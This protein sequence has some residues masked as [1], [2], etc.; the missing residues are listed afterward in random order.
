MRPSRVV[1]VTA[2]VALIAQLPSAAALAGAGDGN[3]QSPPARACRSQ[4]P[5][6]PAPWMQ[7]LP[8]AAASTNLSA[9]DPHC[10]TQVRAG[11]DGVI[12]RNGD[13]SFTSRM[14][15]SP[16]NYQDADGSWHAIDTRLAAD[17]QG[18]IVN[19]A[20]PFSV[21]LGTDASSPTL[22]K[23]SRGSDSVAFD[24]VG[25]ASDSGQ[26]VAPAP[27]SVGAIGGADSDTITYASALPNVDLSYEVL[28]EA[29]K[30]SIVLRAPL[31]SGMSPQFE[32]SVRT[33]GLTAK[34]ADDGTIQFVDA[35]GKVAFAVPAGRA[36]DSSGNADGGIDAAST[37]VATQLLP[38]ADPSVS[39]IVVSIDSAW[40]SDPARVFPVTI[41]PTMSGCD[42]S[43]SPAT[44]CVTEDAYVSSTS[45]ST[46]YNGASQYDSGSGQ[47][48]DRT[49]KSG[50]TNYRS[51]LDLPDLSGLTGDAIVSATWNG[52]AYS[53]AG[54]T[55]VSVSAR[56]ID[57]TW[58]PSTVTN[59][60]VPTVRS[61]TASVSV[62][63]AGWQSIDISSFVTN[64][65]DPTSPWDQDGIRLTGPST[66]EVRFAAHEAPLS[67]QPY[68]DITY[69]AIPT[70]SNLTAGG[71]FSA[72][73]V[74]TAT[75]TL[76]AQVSDVDNGNGL[77]VNYSLYNSTKTTLL[78]SGSG[79]TVTDGHN[80]TWTVGSLSDGTYYWKAQAT[81]GTATSPLSGWQPLVVDTVTPNAPTITISGVTANTWLTTGGATASPH[82]TGS[83]STD[84]YGFFWGIDVGNNPT[85]LVAATSNAATVNN[86]PMT[87]G[88]H[89]IAVETVDKAGNISSL[90]HFTFGWGLGGFTTPADDF[91]TQSK[92]VAHVN[93]TPTYNGVALQWRHADTDTWTNIPTGD[94]TYKSSGTGIGSWPVTAT[95][96]STQTSFPDLV[97]NAASTSSST[98][99][100]LQLRMVVYL[101]SFAYPNS[102]STTVHVLLN[103][104]G[105]GSG[106]ASTSAGPGQVN[107][108][109]GNLELSASDVSLA[110]GSLSRIFD[111]RDPSASGGVFGPGWKSNI[112]TSSSPFTSLIDNGSSVVVYSGTDE[113]DFTQLTNTSY[114]YTYKAQDGSTNYTLTKTSSTEFALDTL[115][116][117]TVSFDYQS[118]SASGLYVPTTITQDFMGLT[119]TI[120]WTGTSSVTYPTQIVAPTPAGVSCTSSPLTTRGCDTLTFDYAT[121]TQ[122]TTTCGSGL[123]DVTGQLRTV[124][125]TAWDPDLSTPAMSTVDVETYCYDTTTNQLRATWD[126]RISPALK[127]TY[128]YDT[129]GHI[130]TI[131]PPGVNAMSFSYTP[132]SGEAASTGRLSAVSQTLPTYSGTT[133]ATTSYVYQ[134]PLTTTGGGAYNLDP[135]TT[136]TWGQQD[137]PTDATAVY[138]PDQTPSGTPPSSYTRATIF[139]IDAE[140][141]LVN[142]AE[143]GGGISTTEYD[144]VG[145]VIR[146]LSP[147]DRAEALTATDTVAESRLLDTQTVYDAADLNVTDTYGPAHQVDLPDDTQRISRQ[148]VTY[149]YDENVPSALTTDAP[150]DL[151]TTQTESAAPIDGSAEQDAR[152][153]SFKYDLAGDDTGWE[154]STPLQTIVDPGTSPHLNLATTTKYDLAT[155]QL[156]ARIL[157]ANPSGG[158]AHETDFVAYTVG[159]NSTDSACGYKP[160]WAGLACRQGPAAQPGTAGLPNIP[161]T[162]VTKYNMYGQPEE[163]IDKDGSTTLRTSDV[164]FDAGGR[165]TAQS[166]TSS[167]GT[168]VAQID[169]VYDNS[170][171]NVSTSTFHGTSTGVVR[172]YDALGRL[173]SYQDA[174]GNT[175][176]YTYDALGN[177]HSV[178]DGK[179][180]TTYTY[181]TALDPRGVLT[182]IS[183]TAV[184]GSWSASYDADGNIIS[185]G[186][187]GGNFI[188]AT[189]YDETDEPIGLFYFHCL[190]FCATATTW[191]SFVDT[192]NIHGERT[193][194]QGLLESYAYTYDSAGRLTTTQ[195]A[196]LFDCPKRTY[197]FDADSNRTTF[198]F[199]D[200]GP[201]LGTDCV[202]TGSGTTATH[203][204]DAADR[205]T[206]VGYSYD[207]LARTTSVPV[208][209]SPSGYAT[210][211]G[212]YTNGRVQSMTANGTTSAYDID[213]DLRAHSWN[214]GS[215]SRTNHFAG[216]SDKAAWTSENTA[217]TTW[218]RDIKAF[219][220]LGA[221]ADQT[222]NATLQLA[223]LHGDV[224]STVSTTETDWLAGLYSTS[225]TAT[226]S[227]TDEYGNP[228]TSGQP[229]GT[230]YD[231]LGTQQR[232]RDPGTGLQLM[233]VRV[234]NPSTGR[235]LQTDLVVGG[236]ANSY[237]YAAGDPVNG[238]DLTGTYMTGGCDTTPPTWAALQADEDLGH[239]ALFYAFLK[240]EAN[241]GKPGWGACIQHHIIAQGAARAKPAFNIWVVDLRQ[242]IN[243]PGNVVYIYQGYHWYLHTKQ[244]YDWVNG[245]IG[246][247]YSHAIVSPLVA[248]RTE[249]NYMRIML[250][251]WF[252]CGPDQ[253]PVGHIGLYFYLGGAGATVWPG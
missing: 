239:Y 168:A 186:F 27:S 159:A 53:T 204:Y 19:K 198:N 117:E 152:T 252:G 68:V 31:G 183:D 162:Y 75:P 236:S 154:L 58:N 206:D 169:L 2:A 121:T 128:T 203:A 84:V 157:P 151:V 80:S 85:D 217:G 61:N 57:Q 130:A 199:I 195:Q 59:A 25:A 201:L 4:A 194:D 6:D 89:D 136:A 105:F 247:A 133:T 170:N 88:W 211:L 241:Y 47:Y 73:T 149:T 137:N 197:G 52:Y 141:Q 24:F 15:S 20:G 182:S 45:P 212:Y 174:D 93:S 228:E 81:D 38:T 13:G 185:E 78:Q 35:K 86:V 7:D 109:T 124:H 10:A 140:G 42:P 120:A 87:W 23:L 8:T 164:T 103:Q 113:L 209:D 108:L 77:S 99:G 139:Y 216:D 60:T 71:R 223:N 3:Q 244:Y 14:F 171:G 5:V 98:D 29:V 66:G 219:G 240:G 179:G 242:Q 163:S 237:D 79:S 28:S 208:A 126:P 43:S 94:V 69:D 97:W 207:S 249:L 72:G 213:P 234:Y 227:A 92:V 65:T 146:T 16:V 167:I 200:A 11:A 118:G 188:S 148:H 232:Q 214:D 144:A 36:V 64:W 123:G 210:T 218:T 253:S 67:Y 1:I 132:L 176:A 49:G 202:P 82:F 191:P 100:P 30:E 62:S 12:W 91:E 41:D 134:I 177:V 112:A 221:I 165:V 190:I 95:P 192:Y 180:T 229:V 96:G 74:R 173:S 119:A 122:A 26:P 189:L 56:P 131:T 222:G 184:S 22:A 63:S 102:S 37:P 111:S 101:G 32:F 160:E 116:F 107:L 83:G 181:D 225:P 238:A 248:V 205:I 135:T 104:D 172:T 129:Y 250:A 34:T 251:D 155:G 70:M 127:T 215:V 231:Y 21:A 46:N 125:Y 245:R 226:W 115:S 161:T 18:Q 143:P 153:T 233:G 138:P 17:A 178:Y 235:F 106:Y 50:T 150:F 48:W 246:W 114:P 9:T 33:E 175:S 110:G 54:T 187:P 220:G 76:S 40:L 44:G 55:P 166:T 224:F 51:Y 243:D 142:T 90:S 193:T 230:R 145:N 147:N 39:T 158:D 196:D 156:T